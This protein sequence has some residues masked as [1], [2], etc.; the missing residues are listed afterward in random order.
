MHVQRYIIELESDIEV[1]EL[2]DCTLF[3]WKTCIVCHSS[4]F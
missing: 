2:G 3:I 4:N 1:E